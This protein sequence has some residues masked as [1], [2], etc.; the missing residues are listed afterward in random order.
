MSEGTGLR[1]SGIESVH[2]ALSSAESRGSPLA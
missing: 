1:A 2:Y